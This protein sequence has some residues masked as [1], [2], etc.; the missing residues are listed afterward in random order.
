MQWSSPNPSSLSMEGNMER[1]RWGRLAWLWAVRMEAH[2][3]WS[4]WGISS[5]KWRASWM[6]PHLPYLSMRVLGKGPQCSRPTLIIWAWSFGSKWGMAPHTK[7]ELMEIV[8]DDKHSSLFRPKSIRCL[9]PTLV[10]QSGRSLCYIL[11]AT[12]NLK[13]IVWA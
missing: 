5:N 13:L 2:K 6:R 7:L 8:R 9:R 11:L 12:M 10:S 4:P 1:V 3:T